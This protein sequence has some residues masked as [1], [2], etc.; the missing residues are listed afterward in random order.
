MASVRSVLLAPLEQIIHDGVQ[1]ALACSCEVIETSATGPGLIAEAA[2]L[3][4]SAAIDRRD[5]VA[6]LEKLPRRGLVIGASTTSYDVLVVRHGRIEH[7]WNPSP[8]ALAALV[9]EGDSGQ[10]V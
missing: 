2:R 7:L 6:E 9:L 10:E 5:A 8:E 3:N 1:D 4:V